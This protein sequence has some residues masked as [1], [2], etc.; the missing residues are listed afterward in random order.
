MLGFHLPGSLMV[1]LC[2]V[3]IKHRGINIKLEMQCKIET[4]LHLF[5]TYLINCWCCVAT[6]NRSLLPAQ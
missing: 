5:I 3:S 4:V 1:H 2:P 6:L